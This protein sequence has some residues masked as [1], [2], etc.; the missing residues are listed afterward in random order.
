M[1]KELPRILEEGRL[2]IGAMGSDPSNGAYGAFMVMGPCT[3][4]LKIVASGGDDDDEVSQGW[5]HVSIST[6]KRVPNWKEMCF[7]KSLFW[8]PEECVVQYHPPESEYVNN[9]QYVLHLWRNKSVAFPMPPSIMVG[10]KSVGEIKT[11]EEA[12]AIRAT[13]NL[14]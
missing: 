1:R 9:H 10:I 8:E 2:R 5:E 13:Y 7:V 4:M 6:R 14:P 12:R 3:E 11:P